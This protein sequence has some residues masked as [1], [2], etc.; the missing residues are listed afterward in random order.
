MMR[1]SQS[2]LLD[3]VRGDG[4][5]GGWGALLL[6]EHALEEPDDDGE[7]AAL[8]VGRKEDG[9]LVVLCHCGREKAFGLVGGMGD[10]E[11]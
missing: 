1:I 4:G 11:W 2:R 7:V 6:G 9:V 5:C 10:V 3:C 8:V